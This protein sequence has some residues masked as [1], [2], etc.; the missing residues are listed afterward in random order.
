MR[1]C[2]GIACQ[3]WPRKY[4]S[5]VVHTVDPVGDISL[6]GFSNKTSYPWQQETC[7]H[8]ASQHPSTS[9]GSNV[10]RTMP[11]MEVCSFGGSQRNSWVDV[12]LDSLGWVLEK[13]TAP[14]SQPDSI[15]SGGDGMIGRK[16]LSSWGST[17]L[18]AQEWHCAARFPTIAQRILPGRALITC[19]R[20]MPPKV[21]RP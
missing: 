9:I 4:S 17:G 2:F 12:L 20:S 5:K 21:C 6:Q 1:E 18:R 19:H 11:P 3:E 7:Q 15:D 14:A 10:E 16:W 13:H 8:E